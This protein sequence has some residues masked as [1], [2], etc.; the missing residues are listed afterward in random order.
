MYRGIS[1]NP[2]LTSPYEELEVPH[3]HQNSKLLG[4]RRDRKVGTPQI[5]PFPSKGF[6]TTTRIQSYDDWKTQHPSDPRDLGGV[7]VHS[8]RTESR[9]FPE[10][11][12]SADQSICTFVTKTLVHQQ[13][14]SVFPSSR[15]VSSFLT[16]RNP[17]SQIQFSRRILRDFS[18][19]IRRSKIYCKRKMKRDKQNID[20]SNTNLKLKTGVRPL[21]TNVQRRAILV[22]RQ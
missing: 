19:T 10:Y 5:R 4:G 15:R 2:R 3:A 12:S 20:E 1:Y 7:R 21:W 18:C 6:V 11:P 22:N 8:S 16:A 14:V 17:T 13:D 9:T